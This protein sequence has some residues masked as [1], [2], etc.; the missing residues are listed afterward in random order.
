MNNLVTL[1]CDKEDG[2]YISN[3]MKEYN[4]S[5][6]IPVFDSD[7][8]HITRKITNE[9]GDIIGGISGS[10][11]MC[12]SVHIDLHWIHEDYRRN[13]I[14]THLLNQVET[15]AKKKGYNQVKLE[16]FDFQAKDFY[17][18]NGYEVLGVFEDYTTEPNR[19][20]LKKS[21]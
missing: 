21:L 18:K 16:T 5:Q 20:S 8:I 14:G 13:G 9:N 1:K 19:Y 7:V 6:V 4:K 2:E 11:R 15:E 17:I 10:V 3:R 12:D